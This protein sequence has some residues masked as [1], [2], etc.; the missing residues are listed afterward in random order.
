[1][2]QNW[3]ST[4]ISSIE[5][6]KEEYKLDT[7]TIINEDDLKFGIRNKLHL[8]D[9]EKDMLI[10]PEVPWY[11]QDFLG[12]QVKFY[13]DLAI[14]KKSVFELQFRNATLNN[15]GYYYDDISL[16]IMMKFAKPNFRFAEI[17]EDL[18]KLRIFAIQT[19]K[20]ADKQCPCLI[21]GCSDEILYQQSITVLSNELKR[22]T[23]EIIKRFVIIIFSQDNIE[24]LQS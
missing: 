4:L 17:G 12:K 20:E 6:L 7:R 24:I 15:K 10:K 1:M 14:L 21:I 2:I 19:A 8:V 9:D 18:D 3:I 5:K 22:F 16:A 11:D 23:E 13:F